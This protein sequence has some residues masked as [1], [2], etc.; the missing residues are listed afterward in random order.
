MN[1]ER[2]DLLSLRTLPARMVAE[3]AGWL[4]GFASHDI[5]VL[6]KAGLLKPLGHPPVSGTKFYATA[7]LEKLR[8][9][10]KWLS[11]ASDAIV[12]YWQSKNVRR[13][14]NKNSTPTTSE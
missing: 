10:I 11:R 6:V 9:D 8:D 1:P 7:T 14:R 3:E 2:K 12:R 5:P 13:T 4:L